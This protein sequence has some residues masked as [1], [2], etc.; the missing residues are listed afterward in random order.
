MVFKGLGVVS[1]EKIKAIVY[2]PGQMGQ[3]ITRLMVEK[4][5]IAVG[6]INR[7]PDNVGKD[8]GEIA[9]LDYPLNV[10]LNNDADEVLSQ[11]EADI[12]IVCVFAEMDRS[13]PQFK[14]C[15]ENGINVITT[16]DESLYPWTS[17]P[18]I[19]AR[20]DR[21]AKEH[22]V[23]VLGA[24]FQ[25][26][27]LTNEI[28]LLSGASHTIVSIEGYQRYNVDDYGLMV[29]EW[30]HVGETL[31]DF[32]RRETEEGTDLSYFRM[33]LET[34]AAGLDL[35]VKSIEQRTE[36]LTEETDL[37]CKALDREIAKGLVIGRAQIT[38][39]ETWQ[40]IKLHGEEVS[41]VYREEEV[42]TNIWSIKG[43]PD[44]YV[45]NDRVETRLQTCTQMVNRIPDVINCEPGYVTVDELPMLRY[46]AYPLHYYLKGKK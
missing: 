14:K 35:T 33:S 9:G 17:S 1:M 22:R 41:K 42:D 16:C 29:A 20:L 19:T 44:T 10:K 31:D 13:F 24:G 5:V 23:T 12:A 3:I 30:H 39:I 32:A 27:F 15:I 36:P 38:D 7:N 18:E 25:D 28:I 11:V 26:T 46:R 45:Q 6:A 2:G 37:F 8:L 21:L 40:G 34:I 4:G 43:F